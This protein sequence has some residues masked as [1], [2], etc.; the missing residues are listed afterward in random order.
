LGNG[1]VQLA[2]FNT[3]WLIGVESEPDFDSK[4]QVH[5]TK[6]LLG[7][8]TGNNAAIEF[9][10][11]YDRSAWIDANG[12]MC[13]PGMSEWADIGQHTG[14][15]HVA[16]A[17]TGQFKLAASTMVFDTTGTTYYHDNAMSPWSVPTGRTAIYV[18]RPTPS[19]DRYLDRTE[20]ALQPA[21]TGLESAAAT[22]TFQS[23]AAVIAPEGTTP[24]AG[25]MFMAGGGL[26][27]TR[28]LS[29]GDAMGSGAGQSPTAQSPAAQ[30]GNGE[31][32]NQSQEDGASKS[33]GEF[34]N[35]EDDEAADVI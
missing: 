34:S 14:D 29:G 32:S 22:R 6:P 18:P 33:E 24:I 7:K 4:P 1:R 30:S 10:G 11:G 23:G 9:G 17:G 19:L 15:I 35:D 20:N 8:F 28:L 21:I 3:T 27:M 5:Y 26:N 12:N 13:V 16:G 2:P 31:A 25:D